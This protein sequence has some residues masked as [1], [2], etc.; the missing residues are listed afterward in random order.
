MLKQNSF[1]R[2]TSTLAVLVVCAAL[3]ACGA[4]P[5]NPAPTATGSDAA[6]GATSYPAP[7]NEPTTYP[8]PADSAPSASDPTAYPPP[9]GAAPEATSGPSSGQGGAVSLPPG[10][11]V[12]PIPPDQV[13]TAVTDLV[14]RTSALASSV[15]VVSAE[16]VEWRDGSLGCPKEGMMYP[17]VITPG[18]K[19]VLAVNGSEYAY[20]ASQD[21]AMFY[22][23]KPVE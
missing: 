22:C 10:F 13:A 18:Y 1:A 14:Q 6:S 23:E 8:P 7:Q 19:L 21:G 2:W 11:E 12:G 5:Q 16:A 17:Q 15:Q 20:H 9:L 3:A 4:A